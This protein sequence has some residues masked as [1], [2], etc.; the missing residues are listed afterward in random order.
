[1]IL[2]FAW[3]AG[4]Q[5]GGWNDLAQIY[6]NFEDA[7]EFTSKLRNYYNA[8]DQTYHFWEWQIVC[9][10]TNVILCEQNEFTE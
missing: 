5:L 6:D 10:K 9:A 8:K 7:V 2:V 3:V 4:Y 1:M